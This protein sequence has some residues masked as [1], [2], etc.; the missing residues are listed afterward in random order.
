MG[1]ED[2]ILQNMDFKR[3]RRTELS[4]MMERASTKAER[5]LNDPEHSI[6]ET[7]FESIYG[8]DA[9]AADLEKV[10]RLERQFSTGV[11]IEDRNSKKIADILEAIVLTQSEMSNWLGNATT[12][13]SSRFD[14]YVNKVDMLAEWNSPKEGSRVLALAVDV[15]F[16]MSGVQKKLREIKQEI[17]KGRL[18]SVRYFKDE[19]GDFMGT[20]NNVPRT[21][22]G[23]SQ[24]IVTQLANLWLEGEK[25][26]LG[27]HPIQRL[28]VDQIATQLRAMASYAT[29]NGKHDAA[30]AYYQ[31]LSAITPVEDSKKGIQLNQLA[32]DPVAQEIGSQLKVQFKS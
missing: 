11:S 19:R 24:P 27:E 14:D 22:I 30:A 18:G 5:V 28:F 10:A 8:K 25:R 3:E 20:R 17:D 1:F 32:F 9:V 13:R 7:E 21:V 23:V 4:P 15:T 2:R 31:A 29:Q 12:L 6:Q 26:Q 16:G